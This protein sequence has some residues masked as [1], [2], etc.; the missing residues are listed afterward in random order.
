MRNIHLGGK[1]A[2]QEI[3]ID[4]VIKK[5]KEYCIKIRNLKEAVKKKNS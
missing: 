1:I 3:G 5:E 4:E 2:K